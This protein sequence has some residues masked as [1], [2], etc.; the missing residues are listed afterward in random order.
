[1]ISKLAGRTLVTIKDIW[2]RRLCFHP[3]ADGR[4]VAGNPLPLT[5]AR[6]YAQLAKISCLG[7]SQG[8]QAR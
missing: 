7:R 3:V 5:R 4:E 6:G 8:Y 1:M 2:E